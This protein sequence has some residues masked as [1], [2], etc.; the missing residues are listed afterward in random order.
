VRRIDCPHTAV[1]VIGRTEA[2]RESYDQVH[3]FQD[4]LTITPLS[5]WGGTGPTVTGRHDP[6][7]DDVTPPLRQVFGLSPADFYSRAA[8]LLR[9]HGP[10]FNDYPILHRM[11]RIGFVAGEPFELDT[12]VPTAKAAL[13]DS[14]QVAQARITQ[15]QKEIGWKRNGWQ[16]ATEAMGNYGTDYLR[17]A[18]VELVGL[19]ANLPEDAIYPI[20]FVDG[21]GEPLHGSSRYVMDFARDEL[22]PQHA[23][24]SLTL[25][26]DEGFQV[27]N[28]L[29]RF[30]IGDRDHLRYEDDG[31]LRLYI[32]SHAPAGE[33]SNWLPAPEGSFNLC[34]RLY[35][36]KPQALDGSWAPPPV[37][38]VG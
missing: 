11:E 26:D 37:T 1:W 24:W 35:Y 13:T 6:S 7:V 27:A 22:P 2:S 34:L 3:E 16:M 18:C 10:H 12:V 20:T 5:F 38:K 33:D 23:F 15:R 29:D 31:S 25:Y 9:S 28:E 14:V 8:D 36:P 17:R 19:G 32:Q 21:D 4:G 30:A